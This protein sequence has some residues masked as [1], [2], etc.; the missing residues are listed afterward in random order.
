MPPELFVEE[1]KPTSLDKG[2]ASRGGGEVRPILRTARR[3]ALI[4]AEKLAAVERVEL[5][6]ALA[7]RENE[8]AVQRISNDMHLAQSRAFADAEYYRVKKDMQAGIVNIQR[9]NQRFGTTKIKMMQRALSK[10]R[11]RERGCV[12]EKTKMG[13]HFTQMCALK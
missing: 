11:P 1:R 7:I 3:K 5:E 8:R 10:A 13:S 6:R 9:I 2:A 12:R 4:E